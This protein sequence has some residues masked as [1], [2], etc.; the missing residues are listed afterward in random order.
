MSPGML[1]ICHWNCDT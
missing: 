1:T